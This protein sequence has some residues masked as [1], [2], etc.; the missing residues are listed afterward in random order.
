MEPSRITAHIQFALFQLRN[1]D[2]FQPKFLSSFEKEKGGR[3]LSSQAESYQSHGESVVLVEDMRNKSQQ[4]DGR[5]YI[6][7]IGLDHIASGGSG[8]LSIPSSSIPLCSAYSLDCDSIARESSRFQEPSVL[9]PV[10]E[11]EEDAEED[12]GV[13][14]GGAAFFT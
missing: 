2:P 7:E 5:T 13:G 8:R 10:A 12:S 9:D 1:L 6:A 11:A 4:G 14:G 3:T